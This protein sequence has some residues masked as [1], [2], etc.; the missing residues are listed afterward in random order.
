MLSFYETIQ[1]ELTGSYKDLNEAKIRLKSLHEKKEQIKASFNIEAD[2]IV[3]NFRR[4]KGSGYLVLGTE[5]NWLVINEDYISDEILK[6]YFNKQRDCDYLSDVYSRKKYIIDSNNIPEEIRDAI[7]NRTPVLRLKMNEKRVFPMLLKKY[8]GEF[9]FGEKEIRQINE[10]KD[11]IYVSQGS[12]VKLDNSIELSFIQAYFDESITVPK[13]EI[14]FNELRKSIKD[15][16]ERLINDIS[17]TE[18]TISNCENT[19]ACFDFNTNDIAKIIVKFLSIMEK[20]SFNYELNSFDDSKSIIHRLHIIETES[21]EL[22]IYFKYESSEENRSDRLPTIS[23]KFLLDNFGIE[24]RDNTVIESYNFKEYE[25]I[26]HFIEYLFIKQYEY[27]K[28]LTYEEMEEYLKTFI[29]FYEGFSPFERQIKHEF[30]YQLPNGLYSYE[31]L[32]RS[33]IM[34]GYYGKDISKKLIYDAIKKLADEYKLNIRIKNN[35]EIIDK[36][37]AYVAIATGNC[38]NQC[39][40]SEVYSDQQTNEDALIYAAQY[41]LLDMIA[42]REDALEFIDEYLYKAKKEGTEPQDIVDDIMWDYRV[43]GVEYIGERISHF[44]VIAYYGEDKELLAGLS[45]HNASPLSHL[46]YGFTS[47]SGELMVS[48][49]PELLLALTCKDIMEIPENSCIYCDTLYFKTGEKINIRPKPDDA[50]TKKKSLSKK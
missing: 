26:R 19:L 8:Q 37:K 46:Y 18:R 5:G 12:A 39:S 33:G 28:M 44:N 29:G 23:F 34:L 49:C 36:P 9:F 1:K 22:K 11:D 3:L 41:N 45:K 24:K 7:S 38:N 32:S 4:L 42:A 27:K 21:N 16:I 25:Y 35:E 40:I 20:K 13:T 31:E 47:E 30:D 48:N 2:D 43:G 6:K 15:S 17:K 10:A 14:K 50:L